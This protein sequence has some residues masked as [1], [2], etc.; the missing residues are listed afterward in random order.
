MFCLGLAARGVGYKKV[1]RASV[2]ANFDVKAVTKTGLRIGLP[3]AV[4]VLGPLMALWNEHESEELSR[5]VERFWQAFI[6]EAQ[7]ND[8]RFQ[9]IEKNLQNAQEMIAILQRAEHHAEFDPSET[10]QQA[11]AVAAANAIAAGS[12]VPRD[13]KLSIIDT[14]NELTETDLKVLQHFTGPRPQKVG[15]LPGAAN[16]NELGTLVVSLSKLESRGLIGQTES[17]RAINMD[18]WAGDVKR[19]DN[20]WRARY[21]ELLPFGKQFVEMLNANR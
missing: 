2:M 16:S 20:Q 10:K 11:Y 6:Y 12:D 8:T 18:S 19:W 3:A 5:R 15:E 7:F 1:S 9:K 17:R 21:Y 4:P 13:T 14:L